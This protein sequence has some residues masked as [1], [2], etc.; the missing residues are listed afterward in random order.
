MLSGAAILCLTIGMGRSYG[1]FLKPITADLGLGRN[2]FAFAIAVQNVLWGVA[3]PF[4][5]MISD[6]FGA[7][8]VLVVGALLYLLGLVIM[9]GSTG[10]MSL[11][12]SAGLLVGLGISATTFSVVLGAVGRLVTPE[13]RALALAIASTGGSFG[14]FMMLPVSQ[15]LISGFGW[16]RA[17]VYLGVA[18]ALI[19]PLALVL[20]GK[21]SQ[22]AAHDAQ[23]P[24]EAIGEAIGHRGYLYLAAGFFVC[25]FH[26]VFISTHLPA[27][28]VDE[29]MTA[30]L[31]VTAVTTIGFF[32]VI[33]TYLWGILAGRYRKKYL[34]SSLYFMRGI[35]IAAFIVLPKTPVSVVVFSAAMGMLWLGTVPLTSGLIAQMFGARYMSTLFGGV[36]LSHQVGAFLGVW[37]GGYAFDMT[38]SYGLVWKLAIALSFAATYINWRIVDEREPP[39]AR[40]L[41]PA[42]D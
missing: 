16:A 31:G 20:K 18:M 6:K 19:V 14:Q 37:L 26:V 27:Y 7:A 39:K 2:A 13:K 12:V 36:Y 38:R 23:S 21:A 3:Q 4:A 35:A 5:G 17:L 15:A 8:R 33:G 22:A 40:V 32:N 1:L 30:T 25:G 11:L 34:L 24:F 10:A 41:V 42:T 9:A 28:L 29:G